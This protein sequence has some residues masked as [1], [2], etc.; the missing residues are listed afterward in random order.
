[1]R[2]SFEPR[3]CH[4]RFALAADRLAVGAPLAIDSTALRVAP[5]YW[6]LRSMVGLG[7]AQLALFALAF[8]STLKTGSANS[9]GC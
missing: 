3:P 8:R 2:R 5:K 9:A 4:K 1:M 7:F 6:S